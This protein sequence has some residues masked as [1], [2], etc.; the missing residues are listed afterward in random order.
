MHC[1]TW[2]K[3]SRSN[4]R[5]VQRL[6]PE[7]RKA[8]PISS[9]KP[10]PQPLHTS[11]PDA[12]CPNFSNWP[13]PVWPNRI[14]WNKNRSPQKYRD[15]WEGWKSASP[16]SWRCHP[17]KDRRL[18]RANIRERSGKIEWSG[19]IIGRIGSGS[20]KPLGITGTEWF[21][22][23]VRGDWVGEKEIPFHSFG[24]CL[25]VPDCSLNL[26]LF[27]M[28]FITFIPVSFLLPGFLKNF[29]R[30]PAAIPAKQQPLPVQEAD[31]KRVIPQAFPPALFPQFF[32]YRDNIINRLRIA[33]PS[34]SIKL[35]KIQQA[36]YSVF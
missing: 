15:A 13:E 32:T 29:S 20:K 1:T 5:W 28:F 30:K 7:I 17:L 2:C 8:K 14:P 22:I 4:P 24:P 35:W 16:S 33:Q 19:S 21:Y 34:L 6:E 9:W 31:P 23:E 18:S 25:M 11:Y 12:G 3:E 26:I 36:P 27:F 10:A